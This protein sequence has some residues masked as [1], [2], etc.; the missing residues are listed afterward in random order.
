MRGLE[1]ILRDLSLL[2]LLLIS[3]QFLVF[4]YKHPGIMASNDI[5]ASVQDRTFGPWAQQCRGAFDFTLLFEESVLTLVPLCIMIL[6]APFRIAYLFRKKRKVEDTPLVH[7]KIVSAF[8]IAI[9]L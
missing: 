5:C 2:P 8:H 6:F 7:M 3:E 1:Y 4:W 9:L